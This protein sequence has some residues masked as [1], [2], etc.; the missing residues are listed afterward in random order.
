M[1][2]VVLLGSTGSI[3]TSCL[4]VVREHHTRFKVVGLAAGAD[5]ESLSRQIREFGPEVV[6]IGHPAA[7]DEFRRRN[8]F[9]NVKVL[10][11]EEGLKELA[12]LDEADVVVNGL[13]GA[14][15]LLPTLEAVKAGKRIALA[16]KESVVLAGEIVMSMARECGA[17]VIPVDS[18]HS[19]VHQ[20]LSGRN[21]EVRR[22]VLTASGGPFLNRSSAELRN[23]TPDDVMRHPVWSMG[24]RICADSATLLNKGFE[25]I[26]ARWLFDVELSRIGVLIHPQCV[27]HALVE[28]S[29]GTTLA[30]VSQPDMRIPIHYAMSFP[31]KTVTG[32]ESCD[33]AKAGPLTFR[34][35]DTSRF[36]CLAMAYAAA[37]VGGVSAAQ[38][39]A[40]D[41]VAVKAFFER[42]IR[43]I[44]IPVVLEKTMEN[45][46]WKP[47]DTVEVILQ[48]DA[49]ARKVAEEQIA[50][51]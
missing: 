4:S 23:V 32:F 28:F 50:A 8:E 9:P 41:E 51:L 38:L 36:P 45:V 35:P 25:V 46:V 24:R 16:N 40:A 15:G 33:L 10:S 49:E 34:E 12:A 20:C 44:D 39:N 5:V 42:R 19:G 27:V 47:A 21:G 18:E 6:S 22:L 7:L 14:L 26:E 43:F 48:A 30:Q 11:G 37:E 2:K 31:E 1:H 17:S 13:V 3:G 29:D